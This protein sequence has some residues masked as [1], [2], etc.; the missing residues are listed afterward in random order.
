LGVS[1]AAE[2]PANENG[3]A[4]ARRKSGCPQGVGVFETPPLTA[5]RNDNPLCVLRASAV[6]ATIFCDL[7]LTSQLAWL[8]FTPM[9]FRLD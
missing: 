9:K 2:T 5:F 7:R 6:D 3:P 4:A 8:N 1:F